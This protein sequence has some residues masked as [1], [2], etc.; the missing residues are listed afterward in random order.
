M[1]PPSSSSLFSL[2]YEFLVTSHCIVLETYL[3]SRS[4]ILVYIIFQQKLHESSLLVAT[5]HQFKR[6]AFQAATARFIHL[7]P[8]EFGIL[9]LLLQSGNSPQNEANKLNLLIYFT[10][11]FRLLTFRSERKLT[12]IRR[13]EQMSSDDVRVPPIATKNIHHLQ[14]ETYWCLLQLSHTR[15][16][17]SLALI[18][19]NLSTDEAVFT[20]PENGRT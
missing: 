8:E 18:T 19:R 5:H 14:R 6:N 10:K 7:D 2:K 20:Y 1:K 3:V 4:G 9:T 15:S 17:K 12:D 13:E 16:S 11:L